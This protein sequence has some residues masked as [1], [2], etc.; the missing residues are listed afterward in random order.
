[1]EY[2]IQE[3]YLLYNLSEKLLEDVYYQNN[4]KKQTQQKPWE[5]PV[6]SHISKESCEGKFQNDSHASGLENN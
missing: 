3:V 1:M 5:P 6:N 2:S 4:G